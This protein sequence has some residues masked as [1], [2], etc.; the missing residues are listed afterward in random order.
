[1]TYAHKYNWLVLGAVIAA[2]ALIRHFFNQRHKGKA[3]LAYPAAGVAILAALAVA[4]APRPAPPP[5]AAATSKGPDL[6]RVSQIVAQRCASCHSAT[7]TQPGFAAAPAGIVLDTPELLL[8][9]AGKV[10]QQAVVLKAMP[11][12]NMT[13]MTDEERAEIGAWFAAGPK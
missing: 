11:I 12:G 1:M 8:R 13:S 9:H 4:I 5:A 6:V 2:A 7:P 10:H 3:N